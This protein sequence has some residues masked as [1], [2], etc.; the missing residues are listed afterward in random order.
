MILSEVSH[1]T[2]ITSESEDAINY[3]IQLL[4]QAIKQFEKLNGDVK[5][6]RNK[7]TPES[8][9]GLAWD[10]SATQ[11]LLLALT[12]GALMFMEKASNEIRKEDH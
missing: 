7:I 1:H 12:Q 3:S 6:Y 2:H 8:A 5:K 10:Y 9:R 11:D 4:Q